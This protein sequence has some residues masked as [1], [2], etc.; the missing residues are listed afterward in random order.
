MQR[1]SYSPARSVGLRSIVGVLT[2]V[3]VIGLL[4]VAFYKPFPVI[5]IT[6][7]AGQPLKNVRLETF[8]SETQGQTRELGTLAAGESRDVS[9]RS[10]EVTVMAL[11]FELGGKLIE[12]QNEPLPLMQGQSMTFTVEV[13][14]KVTSIFLY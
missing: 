6:N 11:K 3:A 7:A 8:G 13:G 9:V 1:A 5:T 12:H 14:G 4:L 10:Y 2:L